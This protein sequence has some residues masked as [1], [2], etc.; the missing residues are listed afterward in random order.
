MKKKNSLLLI[1]LILL[2]ITSCNKDDWHDY[3]PIDMYSAPIDYDDSDAPNFLNVAAVSLESSK[4]DKQVTLDRM[5][6]MTEKIKKEHH[7]VEVIVFP[8]LSLEWYSVEERPEEYQREMA[9]SVPGN[10]TNFMSQLAMENEV[11]LVFGLTEIDEGTNKLYN[12]QVL[13]RPNG[14]LVK[15]RKRN[16]NGADKDNGMSSGENGLITLKINEVNC[17]MFICS[18]MQS[19]SITRELGASEVDVVLQS[20]TTTADF[21]EEISYLGLQLNKWIVFANRY[22]QEDDTDYTGFIQIINPVGTVSKRSEGR[23]VY[24]YRELGIY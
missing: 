4:T 19:P 12:T 20:L 15:Y 8:E 17:A 1:P 3:S 2:L 24:V 13:I 21:N 10:A 16:L 18:D 7:A 5:K 11:V 22:G 9:E 14:E 6:V 23:N